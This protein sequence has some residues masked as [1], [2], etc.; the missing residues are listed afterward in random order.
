MDD[1]AKEQEK[2]Q[3]ADASPKSGL[4]F[5]RL[6][7]TGVFMGL[8]NLVP[9]V[10]G[11]TMVLA[12]GL[13]D[14]FIDSVS[15]LTRFKLSL[16][17]IV[18]LAML[19]GISAF[20]IIA[21]SSIIQF[22]MEMFQPGMLALFIGMT[23]GGAPLLFKELKPFDSPSIV[24]AV[25]GVL[26]MALIAFGLEP[27]TTD[28]SFILFF[29]GGIVGSATMILPGVS[30]SYMLLVLGLYLP[31]IGGVSGIKDAVSAREW[32]YVIS[33]TLRVVVPVGLG[34]VVGIISL[35]NLLKFMLVKYHKPTL[36]FL[37]GLLIGSV[38]GLYPFKQADFDKLPR[39][40]VVDE[41]N[42][43]LSLLSISAF[44]NAEGE[45]PFTEELK[46]LERD[47]LTVNVEVVTDRLPSLED[48]DQA[49][50]KQSVV[51]VYDNS[52]ESEIRRN[53]AGKVSSADRSGEE[54]SEVEL[55]IVPNTEFS[56]VKLLL[57]LIL[58]FV[59]FAITFALGKLGD[60]DKERATA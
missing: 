54:L 19:F 9:G 8:A 27:D 3:Q 38:L 33:E 31:I 32:D 45:F 58:I 18:V 40:A 51:I 53:A 24:T 37:F 34:V 48:L 60:N 55:L 59:G 35:S 56:P 15:S 47:G 20:T 46:E 4:P 49:R 43:D 50:E 13:Y 28:P 30:G 11:G 23:L 26:L 7:I 44:A 12:L 10:S 1:T 39:Y 21:F 52:V 57:V 22:L 5:F 42:Q 6:G 41:L 16:R 2:K 29:L 17:P 14:E 36:G 25:V